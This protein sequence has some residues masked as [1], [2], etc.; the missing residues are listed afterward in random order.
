MA[1]IHK[2]QGNI[3][4][5]IYHWAGVMPEPS[6]NPSIANF[7]KHV[8]VGPNDGSENFVIRYFQLPPGG[9]SPLHTHAHEHGIVIVH[10]ECKLQIGEIFYR[11]SEL[12]AVLIPGNKLHQLTNTGDQPFG[13][14]CTIIRSAEYP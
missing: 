4:Q 6:P 8:L 10:G 1:I 14:F 12:D 7:E 11:L 3:E 13:F 2:F 5:G 9:A